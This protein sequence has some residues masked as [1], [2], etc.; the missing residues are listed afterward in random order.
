VLAEALTEPITTGYG[1]YLRSRD[2]AEAIALFSKFRVLCA[3][4]HGPYG[5][6][7]VN[8]LVEAILSRAGFIFPQGGRWYAGQPVMITRN[9]YT[10]QLFNGDLGLILPDPFAGNELRAFFPAA[11]GGLRTI[12]PLRLPEH[13]TAYAMTVHK[14]QGSEFEQ[15]LLLLPDHRSEVLSRELMYTAISRAKARVELWAADD[16]F[17]AA[18]DHRIERKSGLREILWG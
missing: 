17:L 1:L 13:E 4:R 9:D 3:L 18:V 11:D 2:A 10:L 14:S 15:I 5:V 16:V 8:R 12:L 7:T 6:E